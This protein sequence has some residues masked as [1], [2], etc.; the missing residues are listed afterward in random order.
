M[1]KLEFIIKLT[2]IT[3]L[4]WALIWSGTKVWQTYTRNTGWSGTP[5]KYSI[6]TNCD[7]RG[8][9]KTWDYTNLT[10]D[11]AITLAI[12]FLITLLTYWVGKKVM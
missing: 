4:L 7:E 6:E 5:Y 10:I 2:T 12:S 8:C 1:K 3:L 11:F 9:E